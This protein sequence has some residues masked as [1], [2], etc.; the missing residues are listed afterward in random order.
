M[1]R[2]KEWSKEFGRYVDEVV[3]PDCTE[4]FRCLVKLDNGWLI[5]IP[6]KYLEIKKPAALACPCTSSR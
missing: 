5:D 2:A 1:S 3:D 6:D 4:G